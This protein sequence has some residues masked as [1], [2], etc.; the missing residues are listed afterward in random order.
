M[1]IPTALQRAMER[2]MPRFPADANNPAHR[3]FDAV[4]LQAFAF[5]AMEALIAQRVLQP[6]IT[7]TGHQLRAAL[8]LAWPD[9]DN[10]PDQGET[11][12]TL[13]QRHEFPATDEDG[14]AVVL[15]AGLYLYYDDLPEEGIIP[16]PDTAL[17]GA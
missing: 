3:R 6:A 5:A 17:A 15:P 4:Q 2:A 14:K 9:G 10:D 16:I 11:V 1:M 7:L 8:E 12:V 13:C